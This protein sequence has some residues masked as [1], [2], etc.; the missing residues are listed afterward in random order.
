MTVAAYISIYAALAVFLAG[1]ILR[2]VR[3]ATAPVHLRWELYPVPHEDPQRARHGGS[4]FEISDCGRRPMKFDRLGEL[5]AMTAEIAYLKALREFN[6]PLWYASFLFHGGLYLTVA[7]AVL[8]LARVAMPMSAETAAGTMLHSAYSVLGGVAAGMTLLGA[9]VL[10]WRR[11]SDRELKNYTSAADLFNLV[12]FIVVYG[13]AAAAYWARP[14]G[15]ASVLEFVRGLLAFDASLPV[16]PAIG[17]FVV[18]AAVL[19]AYI[20]FTH[21]AHFIAKYFTYHL[22]RW[23]D[24]PNLPGGTIESQ[25]APHLARRPTWSAAHIGADG[26]K[27]WAEIVAGAPV[28]EVRK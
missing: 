18:L 12:F 17:V 9:M 10:L 27:A 16:A 1:V 7:T 25:V 20:P 3:Y 2:I 28:A 4:N 23:D 21:M 14:S 15:S 19:V 5:R 13:G 22:V 26:H 8:V 11:V 24:R 6:R